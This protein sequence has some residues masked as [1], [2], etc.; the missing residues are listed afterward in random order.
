MSNNTT[1]TT[2]W[3]W[4]RHAPIDGPVGP[5]YGQMDMS[6]I[7][8]DLGS[9]QAL[10]AALPVNALWLTSHL[11]RTKETADAIAGAGDF[12]I[13]P[14]AEPL[15]AEQDFGAWSGKC[16]SDLGAEDPDA[17]SA[18]WADPTGNCPPDGESFANVL[19]R[20]S[21]AVNRLT[22]MHAGHDIIAVAHG[23]SIRAALA[24]AL[25][26]DAAAAMALV[27][28]TLSLT[29]IDHVA[30]GLLRGHGRAWRIGGVNMPAKGVSCSPN[31]TDAIA[32]G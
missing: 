8:T 25:G 17:Q 11:R 20:V 32:R 10:A 24:M 22:A 21:G 9:F 23:G 6:C 26:I 12:T 7:T 15:I 14:T 30:G 29:R 16:W 19:T 28:D 18:F 5:L 27:V 1:I 31:S 4:I 3:W 2:R 13:A